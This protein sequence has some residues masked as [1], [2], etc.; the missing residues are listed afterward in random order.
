VTITTPCGATLGVEALRGGLVL[1]YDENGVPASPA[2]MEAL[3][4]L[5]RHFGF[6]GVIYAIPVPHIPAA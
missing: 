3:A 2:V 4:T 5:A 1:R 6:V